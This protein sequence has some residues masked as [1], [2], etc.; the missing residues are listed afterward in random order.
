MANEYRVID[1]KTERRGTAYGRA[2]WGMIYVTWDGM[3]SYECDQV[4]VTSI[5]RDRKA[6]ARV[7]ALK[8]AKLLRDGVPFEE[9]ERGYTVSR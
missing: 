9:I 2:K 7:K 8:L 1:I 5:I 4:P 6:D 3:L